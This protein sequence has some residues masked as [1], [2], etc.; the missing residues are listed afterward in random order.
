MQCSALPLGLVFALGAA[1]QTSEDGC[2]DN[3]VRTD[4]Y[5][6]AL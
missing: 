6:F 1:W 4:R 5:V 3:R 2:E